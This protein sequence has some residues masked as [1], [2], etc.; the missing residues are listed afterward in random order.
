M[1]SVFLSRSACHILNMADMHGITLFPAYIPTHL[2][3]EAISF[4]SVGSQ[5]APAFS[6]SSCTILP[7]GSMGGGYVGIFAYQSISAVLHLGKSP[8]SGSLQLNTF[9]HPWIYQVSY[10]CS[11]PALFPLVLSSFLSECVPGQF[12]LL[13]LV[14][15]CWME[16][17]WLSH[18]SQHVHR[19]S[20]SV[21]HG[22][23]CHHGCLS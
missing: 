6:H 9:N 17:P 13:T 12:R 18:S 3:V 10:M 22:K 1:A 23:G 21:S 8:A 19:Y 5:V 20:S 2:N 14:A 7:L 15:S 11:L 4:G 16:A